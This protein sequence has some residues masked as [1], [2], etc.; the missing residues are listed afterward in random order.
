VQYFLIIYHD[1]YYYYPFITL[2]YIIIA[3][4]F[5]LTEYLMLPIF[6][7]FSQDLDLLYICRSVLLFALFYCLFLYC[8]ILLLCNLAQEFPSL[9]YHQSAHSPRGFNDVITVIMMT[10]IQW[11]H[12]CNNI[13]YFC[14]L[15]F[16]LNI[17]L[18]T[19]HTLLSH[20][21]LL[22]H[23]SSHAIELNWHTWVLQ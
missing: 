10:V 16:F 11:G 5:F 21:L 1:Y 2:L 3:K 12:P 9:S 8:F 14:Y 20:T 18:W 23:S 7:Y 17:T 22:T 19:Q 6:L 15:V 13:C 4:L